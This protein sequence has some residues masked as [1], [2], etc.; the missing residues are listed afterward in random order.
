VNS[1]VE[2]NVGVGPQF[3]FDVDYP[4]HSRIYSTTNSSLNHVDHTVVTRSWTAR[5]STVVSCLAIRRP[6]HH[7]AFIALIGD[8]GLM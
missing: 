7:E 6:I 4:A 5:N 1:G 2:Y 8:D 3:E